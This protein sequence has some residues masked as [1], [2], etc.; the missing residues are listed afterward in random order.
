MRPLAYKRHWQIASIVILL[1][2]LA[3]ALMPAV[4][5]WD[6]RQS[7]ISWFKGVDKLLHGITFA[8]LA[9]WFAGLYQRQSYWLVGTALLAFGLLIEA[10]QRLVGYRVAEWLDVGADVAGILIGF[11]LA[12]AGLSNWCLFIEKRLRRSGDER[13]I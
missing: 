3:A 9:I 13:G 11:A 4:W 6:D 12:L 2:V 1:I 8:V 10:C 7:G 5:F